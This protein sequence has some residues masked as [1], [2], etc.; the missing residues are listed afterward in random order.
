MIARELAEESAVLLS[1]KDKTL[2][3]D[4]HSKYKSILIVG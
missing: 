3:M 4:F 1:N 2:P